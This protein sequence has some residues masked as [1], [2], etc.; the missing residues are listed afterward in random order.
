MAWRVKMVTGVVLVLLVSSSLVN[1]TPAR[2]GGR[3]KVKVSTTSAPPPPPPSPI[4]I[5]DEDKDDPTVTSGTSSSPPAP[6]SLTDSICNFRPI[7]D[8]TPTGAWCELE[9]DN[10]DTLVASAVV[11]K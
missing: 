8:K 7:W 11:N 1:G 4:L 9:S 10:L 2:K 6:I 3:G 5:E